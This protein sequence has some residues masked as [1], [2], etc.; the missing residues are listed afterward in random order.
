MSIL[1]KLRGSSRTTAA[2]STRTGGRNSTGKGMA[3]G[4]NST[5]KGMT[6]GRSTTGKGMGGGRGRAS[7][8]RGAPGRS[9]KGFSSRG[10]ARTG[11]GRAAPASSGRLSK[12][13]GS[14]TRRH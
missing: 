2:R 5:G 7:S 6:G 1:S 14:L 11:G 12:L 9:F 3:S 4:R 8:G 10:Q 13:F